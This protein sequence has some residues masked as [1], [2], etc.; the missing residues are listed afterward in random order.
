M[1]YIGKQ[2]LTGAYQLCDTITTSATATYN[3]LV[4]GSAVIPGSANNCIV[5]LNGVVQAPVSAFT[6]LGSTI[7]FSSTL[8]SSDVIDFILIL[9]NVFDIG[10]P[11]DG[12]VTNASIANSTIDLTTKV[13][14]I[15]PV[16]NGGTNLSSGFANGIIE[17][18]MW[19]L[20]ADITSNVNPISANLER[21]DNASFAKIGTGMSVASGTWTF[22]RTGLYYVSVK[23]RCLAPADNVSVFIAGTINNSTYETLVSTIA[24]APSGTFLNDA[25]GS[26]YINV[27]NTSNVKVQ[28]EASSISAG[29]TVGG[30]SSDNQTTFTFIR[31]G[32]SQ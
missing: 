3:L 31:L 11:T 1:P 18:D 14:G 32:D 26:T 23:S 22:P 28:F 17:A 21:V 10:K 8:S 19:R 30:S 7:T 4:G 29:S 2:P 12:S 9:G 27:T 5:S 6:V 15:L 25:I 20:T 13:T 24:S 16:A